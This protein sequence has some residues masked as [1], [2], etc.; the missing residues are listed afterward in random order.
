M[1]TTNNAGAV[2]IDHVIGDRG[3]LVVRLAA[4]EIR[5]AAGAGDRVVVRTPDGR[6]LPDRVVVETSDDGLT[7]REK[8]GGALGFVVS[9]RVIQLEL[10]LPAM[11]EVTIDTAGGWLDAQGLTGEQRYRTVAGEIRLRG[12]AGQIELSTVS[13]DATI[14]LA[15][16]TDLAIRS[17]SGDAVVRGG[18]L[19]SLRIGTTS[20]DVRV[21]SP[22]V[23]RSGNKIE[24]LSGDVEIVAGAGMH[25]EARTISGDLVSDLPHRSEGRMGRRTLIIGDGSIELGFRSVSGDLRIHDGSSRPKAPVPPVPPLAP[26]PPTSPFSDG[27]ADLLDLD[28]PDLDLPDIDAPGRAD[29]L[30]PQADASEAVAAGDAAEA[31]RMDILRALEQGELDVPTALDRLAT[32]DADPTAD[33]TREAGND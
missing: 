28:V 22:L 11:A 13:G 6:S 12:G 1:T 26:L 25:V 19:D 2:T 7:I 27:L 5:L 29:R 33:P 16:A 9:R 14:E 17:V 24:T 20:G 32:L 15:G 31:Q 23:G 21:D 18:S 3:R 4:A 8:D 30:T 10:A